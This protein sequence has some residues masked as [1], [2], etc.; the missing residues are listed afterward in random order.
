MDELVLLR[1]QPILPTKTPTSALQRKLT[2]S[3]LLDI[4]SFSDL[5][6][7]FVD[8]YH[9]GM[10]VYE[11]GGPKL[12]DIRGPGSDY[13]SYLFGCGKC[14]MQCRRTVARVKDGPIDAQ[15]GARQLTAGPSGAV[16]IPCFSGCHYMVMPIRHEGDLLGRVVFG[17]CV[18]EGVNDLV[19]AIAALD[20][21]GFSKEQ[22]RA[23]L[24]GLRR[25][26]EKA[27][28][29]LMTH[30]GS[31]VD[32]LVFAGEKVY[33]T[34][35]LHM[36]ATRESFRDMEAKNRELLE[37]NTRLKELDHLKSN[38]LATVSHEL[39][40]PLTSI[41]GYS[42][43]LS[44]GLAGALNA[45]QDEYVRTILEKGE[46]LLSLIGSILDVTKIEAGRVHLMPAPTDLAEV[47]RQ[48]FTTIQPLAQRKGVLV[49]CSFQAELGKPVIDKDKV[50]QVLINL[51]A[52]AVKFTPSG[53][54]VHIEVSSQ[55]PEGM[56]PA[57]TKGFLLAV[58]DTGIGIPAEQHGRVFETFYQVDQS[59]TREYG[60]TGL[61][62]AIVKNFVEA[63]GG[64][65]KLESEVGKGARFS[66]SF[67]LEP[68]QPGEFGRG[69]RSSEL[70]F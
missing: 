34:S 51:L 19:P 46:S 48:S 47:V 37:S 14:E 66:C 54:K 28:A 33:L 63:H 9:I 4:P 23:L 16:L 15:G 57:G 10:K 55:V 6:K 38:F 59:S 68:A 13:C 60:G 53:G 67:P 7:G 39:R 24:K 64:R 58:T 26:P 8:I 42:E 69:A 18:A 40:T 31:I 17:P 56:L 61:G 44:E 43:M 49:D 50:R 52:N 36:E 11:E 29:Q 41:I 35:Q 70:R 25:V 20:V 22:A 65:V 62:L 45:E 21:P 1:D 2:L 30:F 27:F 32:S 12:V 5:C 3:A